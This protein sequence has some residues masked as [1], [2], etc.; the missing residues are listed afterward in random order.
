MTDWNAV[1]S[2]LAD[3]LSTRVADPAAL[4][5]WINRLKHAEGGE[6]LGL[7]LSIDLMTGALPAELVAELINRV[8]STYANARKAFARAVA[9]YPKPLTLLSRYKHS[10]PHSSDPVAYVRLLT[11]RDCLRFYSGYSFGDEADRRFLRAL[12]QRHLDDWFPLVESTY[13]GGG[14]GGDVFVAAWDDVR[15]VV[16]DVGLSEAQRAVRIQDSYGLAYSRLP[17]DMVYLKYDVPAS[18]TALSHVLFAQPTTLSTSW[19]QPGTFFLTGRDR[20]PLGWGET[21]SCTGAYGGQRE[22]V[23]T[24]LEGAER[25]YFACWLGPIDEVVLDRP[26]HLREAYARFAAARA[27]RLV[28]P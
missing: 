15:G 19:E 2:E 7:C 17:L 22:R 18:G 14:A 10:H 23:H 25:L 5:L 1:T 24:A 16:S 9:A 4:A 13:K 12:M 27:N 20:F 3:Y 28:P 6:H 11:V 8:G 21:Q 26:R